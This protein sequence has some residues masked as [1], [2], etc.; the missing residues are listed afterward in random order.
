MELYF[1]VKC[2]A[3]KQTILWLGTNKCRTFTS[4]HVYSKCSYVTKRQV[5]I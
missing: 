5:S 4:R 2:S 1:P 3:D